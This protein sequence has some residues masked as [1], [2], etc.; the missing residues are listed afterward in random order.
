MT[1]RP[2]AADLRGRVKRWPYQIE[3]DKRILL[4]IDGELCERRL[5]R[6][7]NGPDIVP[8]LDQFERKYGDSMGI[9]ADEVT[10]GFTSMYEVVDR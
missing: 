5:N 10:E 9:G 1:L 6:I 7:T 8:V 2:R 4:R 3:S